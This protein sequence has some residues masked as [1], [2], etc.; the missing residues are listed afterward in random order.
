MRC[1]RVSEYINVY[2]SAYASVWCHEILVMAPEKQEEF[3]Y[4]FISV[5]Q[6]ST[7]LAHARDT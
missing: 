2:A 4:K 5:L 1:K 6:S 3:F 7:E